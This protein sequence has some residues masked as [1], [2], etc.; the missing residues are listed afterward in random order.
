MSVASSQTPSVGDELRLSAGS[1]GRFGYE[2]SHY[3]ELRPEYEE[4]F[5]RW[6]VHLSPEDWRGKSFLDVGCGTGRNSY[7]PM[8]YG[9][10]SGK[11]VDVDRGS[12]AVARQNLAQFPAVSVEE[13]SAYDIG[14][15]NAYDIVFS[16]G[17]IHHL[18]S[19]DLA[20]CEMI[21]AAKPGGRVL[22]WVYGYENNEWIVRL[23]DPLRK[24]LFSRLPIAFVHH[25][26][27]Y[28]T[29]A[30]WVALRAGIGRISYFNLLRGLAFRHLR[31]IVFDQMLPK[32]AHYWPRSKVEA[33]LREPGL[34]DVKLAWVN[35]LSW[36]AIG[37]KPVPLASAESGVS[38]PQRLH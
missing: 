32:I 9:A 28:P 12:L 18:E 16:I 30:L 20:I 11:A 4:Q 5:R 19:P 7:W 13:K 8:T 34:H 38:A 14:E 26:S 15:T 35:E 31:S 37:T 33:M 17:V 1:P 25:L 22:I 36:S 10:A 27:V 24:L 21:R 2:W 6:T 23:F 3:S 29:V